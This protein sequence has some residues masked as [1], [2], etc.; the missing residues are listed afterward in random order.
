MH[1]PLKISFKI[2]LI[3]I[4]GGAIIG[5]NTG[6]VSGMSLPLITCTLFSPEDNINVSLYQGLF[7]ASILVLAAVGSPLG[8]YIQKIWSMKNV[9]VIACSK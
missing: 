5:Y 3:N 8:V 6:I 1:V 2:A 4:L 9:K 7:T